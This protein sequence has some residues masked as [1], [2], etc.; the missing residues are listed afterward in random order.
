LTSFNSRRAE[1]VDKRRY[2]II[3][4]LG[5]TA[6]EDP[7]K[8]RVS[9]KRYFKLFALQTMPIQNLTATQPFV[10][11]DDVDRLRNKLEQTL[12]D[13]VRVARYR[14]V[15]YIL[16]GHHSVMA[17]RLR[18]DREIPVQFADFDSKL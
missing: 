16:D 11:V 17:A 10:R 12:P 4:S 6:G 9:L 1:A 14:G 5:H 2:S 15:N 18:G 7:A 8:D 13:N 3:N